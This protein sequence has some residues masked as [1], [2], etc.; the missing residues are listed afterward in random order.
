[1]VM[2]EKSSMRYL[3]LSDP[4]LKFRLLLRD[5]EQVVAMAA[6]MQQAPTTHTADFV[7][8]AF[9]L[10]YYRILHHSPGLVHRFYQDVSKLG[11]PEE[12]GAMSITTTMQAINDKILSLDYGEF[13]ADIITD[14]TTVDAQESYNGGVLV[15]VA[16][17][18]TGK[19]NV[20]RKFTQS[21]FLAPQETGYFVLNDVFRY[22]D[23]ANR[24]NQT[25]INNVE[26]PIT[27]D[28]G[29]TTR[30]S[31]NNHSNRRRVPLNPA[32]INCDLIN[33]ESASNTLR[34]RVTTLPPP[35]PPPPKEPTFTCPICMGPLVEEMSTKCGH[36]FC[37]TCINSA[38]AAQ[39]KCPTCRK[40]VTVNELIRVFLPATVSQLKNISFSPLTDSASSKP[41]HQFS[42]IIFID[43][44]HQTPSSTSIHLQH[45]THHCQKL[46]LD[47]PSCRAI[48]ATTVVNPLLFLVV[49]TPSH[50]FGGDLGGFGGGLVWMFLGLG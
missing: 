22:V 32:I 5:Q 46:E 23:D 20:R 10:Q 25:S 4:N 16:G 3:A 14:I 45:L 29:G 35:P 19:D 43:H 38:I 42:F 41:H 13:S 39:S 6:S 30:M 50:G 1:M 36:I 9:V 49:T 11:R 34:E 15:L 48:V 28:Q 2:L 12:D 37:K 18:L 44:H 24:G 26:A 8:N 21:F 27:P 7:A 47:P 40:K 31:Q 17:Y 33:L